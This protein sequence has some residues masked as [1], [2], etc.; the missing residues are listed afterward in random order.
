M[1]LSSGISVATANKDIRTLRRV[2]NLA[3]SPREYLRE[4]ENP[5]RG[6]RQRK[7]TPGAIR[8]V[9][10]AEFQRLS[11]ACKNLWWSAFLSIAYGSGLRCDEIVNL[12][13]CDIDFANETIAVRAK[14]K[15]LGVLEWEPKGR[16]NRV[17]PMS[18]ETCELLKRRQ[19]LAGKGDFYLFLSLKRVMHIAS[20]RQKGTWKAQS[21]LVNNFGRDFG[22]IR[23]RA[24]L[25]DCSVHDLRR[26]AITNW[27]QVLPIQV[28][29]EMAG[30]ENIETTRKYY[31]TVRPEDFEAARACV[32][33][34]LKVA[35]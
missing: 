4:G 26:S 6:I 32:N 33:A 24:G 12:G 8:Y 7:I 14:K 34:V 20:R 23:R 22:V 18:D 10:P 28:V 21:A 25:Q 15:G 19:V 27:S 13:W 29:Q 1:R 3:I 11:G 31:L 16:K 17:V 5:F 35:V 9:S 2:F 30:H